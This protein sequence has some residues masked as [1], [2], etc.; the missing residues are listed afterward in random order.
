MIYLEPLGAQHYTLYSYTT[1]A[2]LL[3]IYK[4][5]ML[6][7]ASIIEKKKCGKFCCQVTLEFKIAV[8][9][10]DNLRFSH[11]RNRP[12]FRILFYHFYHIRLKCLIMMNIFSFA[13]SSIVNNRDHYCKYVLKTKVTYC[14]FRNFDGQETFVE[15]ET[16]W[17]FFIFFFE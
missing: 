3:F 7:R 8:Y 12:F 4:Y 17:V 14:T 9:N 15:F 11:R 6:T 2:F 13:K 16:L 5:I 1:K 10:I